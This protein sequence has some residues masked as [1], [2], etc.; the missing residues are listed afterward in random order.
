MSINRVT[1]LCG[2][3][4]IALFGLPAYGQDTGEQQT[5]SADE[6]VVV[7]AER[8]VTN[9]QTTAISA[10]VLSGKTL[11]KKGITGLTSLQYAAP[12]VQIADYASANTFNIRGVGQAKVDIDLPSGVTIYRDGV[13]TLTGYFQNAPYYDIASVEVLRGPQGVNAGKSASAGA[14]FIR[15]RDPELGG[16]GVSGSLMAG[17]GD[18]AFLETT[19][20]VNVPVS[21]TF[22]IRLSFHGEN[23]DSLFDSIST[24]PLPGAFGDGAGPFDGDDDRRLRSVR[25]GMLWK[26]TDN[27]TATFKIDY[28]YLYFGTHITTGFKAGTDEIED[29]RKPIVN[30]K[31]I[32][33]DK[34]TRASLKLSYMF[35]NGITLNSLSGYSTVSTLADWDINGS[36]PQAF[37]FVSGGNFFN[38]SQEFNVLS[39]DDGKL[40]WVAGV[41][42]Q[43]YINSIPPLAFGF[44]TNNGDQ[45]DFTTPWRKNET[46][47]AVF[48]QVGYDITDQLQIEVGARWNHYEFTQFTNF[49]FDPTGLGGVGSPDSGL[50]PLADGFDGNGH[51]QGFEEDSTDWKVA[52]NY[53]VNDDH[54]VY[55]LISRG[56]TP[57]SIN[58]FY[59]PDLSEEHL[60]YKEMSV[61]NY[62][63]GWKGTFADGQLRT[64]LNVYYQVF[65]N[66][67]ADFGLEAPGVP[68]SLTTTVLQNA[69]TDSII[70]GVEFGFQGRFGDFGIDGGLAYSK[71]E[72]GNFGRVANEFQS[73]YGGPDF[74]DLDGARTPFA[75]EWTANVGAEYTIHVGGEGATL[76]PRLDIGYRGKAYARLFQNKATELEAVTLLNGNIRYENGPWAIELW[77]TN[78][79]DEKYAGAKQNVEAAGPSATIP[80]VHINGIVYGGPRR[81][82]GLRVTHNF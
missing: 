46:G 80:V 30:G 4:A 13:P 75:P 78:L 59:P 37:G 81:L 43:R 22:A 47:Y 16:D 57:G 14:V 25:L 36:D 18:F 54:F 29:I 26:P 82:F 12:G 69:K 10:T 62:E 68:A 66:Y 72:L 67:Q 11:E 58:L 34:G 9:L 31:H 35:D 19:G 56:H 48:G 42:I 65:K 39:P 60:D 52:L 7:T 40:T 17:V 2:V 27:F 3:S 8:R 41:F 71:S 79:T 38:Y 1:F 61:V 45:V 24:N 74:L 44:I 23:R 53:Q 33:R 20:V 50:F 63:A 77:G 32:Y 73:F 15:T 28:D 51:K 64:Q 49:A 6:T 21:D 5:A 70:Y 76:T 55:G